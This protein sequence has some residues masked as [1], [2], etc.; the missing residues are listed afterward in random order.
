MLSERVTR[1]ILR[2]PCFLGLS[3]ENCRGHV[4]VGSSELLYAGTWLSDLALSFDAIELVDALGA[5]KVRR[6]RCFS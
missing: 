6:N 5:L 1:P 2:I 4:H 3:L